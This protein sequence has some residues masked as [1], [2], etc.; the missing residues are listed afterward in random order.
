MKHHLRAGLTVAAGAALCLPLLTVTTVA[1]A[2]EGH[3]DSTAPPPS[4]QFQKVTLNDRPGEP[5]DLAVLPD[6]DVLHT[7]RAGVIWHH[8]AQT[9]TNRVAGRIPVYLHDEEGLQSIALDPGYD[10]KKNTWVYMYY[11]PPLDTPADD[12][13]TASIN[14]GDAPETGTKAD[15]ER[16]DGFLRVSKFRFVD[17]QVQLGTERKVLD[18]P[19]D[20]GMCC[21]VGGDIVF[22]SAGNLILSTGDDSNPF[23]SDGYV[24]LDERADRNPAFDAQ[25]TAANTNDLR[26]KILRITPK[27]KGGYTIPKGNLFRPG[28]PK[29]RPEIYSMGWR[30]P[31]RIEIDPETD[32]LWV[33]DYSPDAKKSKASR[34][35]AGHGKWAVVDG[36]GNY[37][38]PYCATA[39]M[40]YN[41]YD[42][43]K[44]KSGKKFDCAAPV[45]TSVHNTGKRR[46][47][48]VEQ[49]E[50][51][52]SYGK[53]KQFPQ[54][55]K[56]GI[57]PMAGPAYQFDRKL[58]R[59]KNPVA[60]PERY[61]GT[62]LFY[63]WTRDY[64][65][66]IHVDGTK[67]GIEDVLRGF[68]VDNPMDMEFGPDGAL[69]VLEYGDG[70]F[71][72]NPDAQLA[73]IDFV[74]KGG[75]RSPIPKITAEPTAGR[76][77][78]TVAFS[79]RGTKDPDGDKKLRYAWDFDSDGTVDSR[80]RNGTF[81][82][83]QDGSYRASLRVT[84][85]GGRWASA[86]VDVTVGNQAPE[87]EFV[88]PVEDQAF[89]FG[90]TV[91][92]EL[93]VTDDEPVDCSRVTVTYVLGH[94]T[95]GHP[96]S[97]AT[98]CSGSLVTTVPGGHDPATD[99]L[100]AVFVA[101]YTDTGSQPGLSGYAE[102]VLDPAG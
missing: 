10:G 100:A 86:D 39:R 16:Y 80:K 19:V 50:V 33:A 15:F 13:S 97:T 65:K 64:I 21:H 70:Y 58:T 46:L 27:A 84:D 82:Y 72:E 102:V 6:G 95:H 26:G 7:T 25:R 77:P 20:R 51:W 52:Y 34:G 59:G 83:T 99:D 2:H 38:W 5:L 23:Q 87:V 11:S 40:P 41:D 47:P 89:R 78:L 36:P 28:T 9:G 55:G 74:G 53:S 98:G 92:Y 93:K 68:V 1:T 75:N 42:F 79:S 66:G 44:K 69:Y 73:R 67:V 85:K 8:D 45:N 56:G 37:G 60:W 96:Q 18:V 49:P 31:F 24:P 35:P 63:E 12:E 48:P 3:S 61:D 22:D 91:S 101:E 94:D 30:N 81:T 71:A 90:D 76:A 29:T 32:N 14:E 54:L 17:G 88:T 4:K 62:P 43:A 57:A